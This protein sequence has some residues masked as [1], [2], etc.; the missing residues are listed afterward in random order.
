MKSRYK[1]Y[2]N[3]SSLANPNP[4]G[5]PTWLKRGG[6]DSAAFGVIGAAQLIL[7]HYYTYLNFVF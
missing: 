6:K 1:D 4:N 2:T 5:N 7:F 3:N